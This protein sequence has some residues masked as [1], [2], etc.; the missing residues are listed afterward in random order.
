MLVRNKIGPRIRASVIAM[1]AFLVVA[2]QPV[3][4]N[5]DYTVPDGISQ[6]E[7]GVTHGQYSLDPWGNETAVKNAKKLL[8]A[9]VRYQNQHIYGWGA[10]NPNP[11]HGV[12]DWKTL[13][14]RIDLIRSMG[15]TPVIT[16]CCAPDWMTSLSTNTSSYPNLPPTPEHYDNFADLVRRIAMRYPDVKH[17]LVWNEM[18][19]F[20]DDSI[21]NWNYVEYTKMYNYVYEALKA[22]NPTI[23]VGG[24]Y[25]VIEGTGSEELG[26]TDGWYTASPI[27]A[28]DLKVIDYWLTNKRGADF[29]VVDRKISSDSHDPN[30][31][32]EAELM[33]LTHWFGDI[34]RQITL[35]TTLPVWYAEDYFKPSNNWQFQAAGLASMLYNYVRSS[36]AV[37]LRWSPQST[38]DGMH[39]D[40]RQN[41]FSDTRVAGGGQ[42][43]PNYYV[44]KAFHEHFGAGT[45]LYRTISSSPDVEVLASATKTLLINKRSTSITVSVNGTL[46]TMAGYQVYIF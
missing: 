12:Y 18:K 45:Q 33:Q 17:Y 11:K 24:P 14:R 1:L 15:A 43:F 8:S 44:Y 26:Y 6:L 13:D 9:A 2:A 22:V 23:K 29:I 20:W 36:V 38:S 19:G 34:T 4:I 46:I 7:T 16:L 39:K 31:Y 40:N 42:P 37:S 27:T 41:L 30:T 5:V 32:S 21:N 25:L 28:R 3:I 10:T 35:R